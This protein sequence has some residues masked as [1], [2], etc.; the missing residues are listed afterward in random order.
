[1]LQNKQMRERTYISVSKNL[2]M[3]INIVVV[4]DLLFTDLL[5]A[6]KL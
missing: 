3:K 4:C 2:R 5:E 1:M 6:K